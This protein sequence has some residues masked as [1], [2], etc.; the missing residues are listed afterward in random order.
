MAVGDR[1]RELL[2]CIITHLA[3]PAW[4]TRAPHLVYRDFELS[5][6]SK[7][8]CSAEEVPRHAK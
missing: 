8:G 6:R 2:H 4:Y 3:F 7:R 1:S 5:R